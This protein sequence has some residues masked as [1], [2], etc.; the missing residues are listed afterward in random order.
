MADAGNAVVAG[1]LGVVDRA[2]QYGWDPDQTTGR[3]GE[4]LQV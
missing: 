1:G 3:V 4:G 2:G